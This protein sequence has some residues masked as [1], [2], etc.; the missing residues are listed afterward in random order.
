MEFHDRR[1]GQHLEIHGGGYYAKAKAAGTLPNLAR[2]STEPV[3]STVKTNR[4]NNSFPDPL[5]GGGNRG[6]G[7]PT[8]DTHASPNPA[9]RPDPFKKR[10]AG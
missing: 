4:F 10:M 3:S 7:R 8:V 5:A 1:S 2:R 9:S 6:G